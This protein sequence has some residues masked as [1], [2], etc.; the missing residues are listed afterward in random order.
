MILQYTKILY[1]NIIVNS[2][3][4]IV[5]VKNNSDKSKS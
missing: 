5:I 1:E 3:S 2:N 4:N